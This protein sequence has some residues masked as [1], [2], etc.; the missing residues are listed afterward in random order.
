[1]TDTLEKLLARSSSWPQAAQEEL[2]RA[3]AEIEARHTKR[4]TSYQA[5]PSELEAID[6]GLQQLRRGE[7]VPD[8]EMEALFDRDAP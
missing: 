6:E 2:W 1:M 8:E 5:T 4:R 3:A 7:L